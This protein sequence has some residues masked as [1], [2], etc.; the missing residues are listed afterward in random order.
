IAPDGIHVWTWDARPYPIF[1][2]ATD[3]WSDGPNWETGH[4]LTGRLGSTP[5]D[6]LV[7]TLLGDSGIDNVETDELGEGPSGYVVDRPMTPRAM[8]DPLALAY[9]FDAIELDGVLRFVQ[10]GG[11]PV[12]AL[13]EDDLVLP[14]DAAP[15]ALI[16]AQESDLPRDVS[17]GY[18]D[19]GND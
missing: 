1:P 10:R 19:I 12:I 8:I 3:V 11:A 7:S 14:D 4:W 15:V 16:R 18:T 2:A 6:G 17:I 5:L 9:A 13:E